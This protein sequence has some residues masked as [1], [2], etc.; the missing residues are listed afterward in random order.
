VGGV[1]IV[2]V[3]GL[4]LALIAGSSEHTLTGT[5]TVFDDSSFGCDL[6]FGYQDM[7]EGAR[8]LVTDTDDEVIASSTLD[9]GNGGSFCEFPFTVE[10]IP[11]REEYWVEIGDR[12]EIHYDK[13]ELEDLNWELDLSLGLD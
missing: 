13:S 7:R 9:E 2:A 5:I 4:M 3:V 10:D 1:G 11:D 8:V 6:S 12:G